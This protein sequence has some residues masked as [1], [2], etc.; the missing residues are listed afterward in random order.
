VKKELKKLYQEFQK[1]EEE[2]KLREKTIVEG[3]KLVFEM[4]MLK[5]GNTQD[6]KTTNERQQKR[7]GTK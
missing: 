5:L 4:W 7:L 6:Q 2:K 3:A 1:K